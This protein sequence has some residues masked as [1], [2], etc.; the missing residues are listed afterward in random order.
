MKGW[1][2]GRNEREVSIKVS[3]LV[4]QNG[5]IFN[6]EYKSALFFNN[7]IYDVTDLLYYFSPKRQTTDQAK[8]P[9]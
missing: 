7:I 2:E 1:F 9:A 6:E 5:N 3:H 4:A 8:M